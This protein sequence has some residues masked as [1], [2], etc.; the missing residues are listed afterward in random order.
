ML[1][2]PLFVVPI[3]APD[4]TLPFPRASFDWRL[5]DSSLIEWV[6]RATTEKDSTYT[7]TA[8]GCIDLAILKLDGHVRLWLS[9]P[10]TKAQ[11]M[12]V[13][14]GTEGIYIRLKP[15]VHLTGLPS[16]KMLD[17]DQF[18]P[19]AG[20]DAF[21]LQNVAFHF[22]SFENVEGFVEKL[23]KLGRLRRDILVE[24][25]LVG[26]SRNVNART[27]Q[28]HFL[29][30]TGIT[31][32]HMYQIRRATQAGL[33]LESGLKASRVAAETGFTNQS[34][35]TNSLKYFLGRTP[36]EIVKLNA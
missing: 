8:D 18:L 29:K 9:G 27:V 12:Q 1:A 6:W 3:L 10:T 32:H 25:T 21:W 26:R 20:S 4:P 31:P 36:R 23:F 24:D 28:R 2:F 30:T 33:L 14:A 34:H 35:M 5:S 13:K 19:S 7:V 11:S 15:G 16:G 17:T 22:P